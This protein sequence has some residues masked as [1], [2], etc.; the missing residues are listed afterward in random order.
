MRRLLITYVYQGYGTSSCYLDEKKVNVYVNGTRVTACVYS[1]AE[2]KKNL[3]ILLGCLLPIAVL[4][5]CM[6]A[7][8]C[9]VKFSK[10]KCFQQLYQRFYQRFFEHKN[11]QRLVTHIE[12][13]LGD[14]AAADLRNGNITEKV[15]SVIAEARRTKGPMANE[16]FIK[17]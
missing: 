10:N 9:M 17:Y 3:A 5:V 14:D 13:T 11:N 6:L 2:Y 12:M 7:C 4:I 15:A 1:D 16:E 8:C